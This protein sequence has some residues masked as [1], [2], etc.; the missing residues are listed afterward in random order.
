MRGIVIFGAIFLLL[1]LVGFGQQV[2]LEGVWDGTVQAPQGEQQAKVT[3]KKNG[4]NYT[5]T[6]TGLRGEQALKNIKVDGNKMT[7]ISEVESP[8]GNIV[9]SYKFAVEGETLKGE[10]Q[11]DFG[12]QTYNFAYSLKRTSAAPPQDGQRPTAPPTPRPQTPQ[13]Q[14][15]QSLDYFVGDWTAKWVVRESALGGGGPKEEQVSF[16]RIGDGKSLDSKTVGKSEDGPYQQ[17]AIIGFD[18]A[19]K[20][21]TFAERRGAIQINSKGDWSSPIIIRFTVDPIK[22]KGQTL[23]LRRT[24]SIISAFSFTVTEEL[25]ENG[26]PFVRLGQG[27]F[28]KITA[29]PAKN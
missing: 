8:Q 6:I 17:S 26:G 9:V 11:V 23:Q 24:M 10:G 3:L 15:K 20:A 4:D 19:T 14:Q 2:N 16:K 28:T 1:A 7:A 21:I 13:P 18:E 27:V 22:V 5:G 25:S 29:A 12:G